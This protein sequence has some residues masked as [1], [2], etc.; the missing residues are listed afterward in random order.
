[1]NR[2]G[3]SIVLVFVLI[4]GMSFTSCSTKKKLLRRS[5]LKELNTDL[6]R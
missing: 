2:T 6:I 4:L 1:M 3:N 5:E